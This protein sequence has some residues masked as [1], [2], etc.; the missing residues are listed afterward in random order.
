MRESPSLLAVKAL[1]SLYR[2]IKYAGRIAPTMNTEHTNENAAPMGVRSLTI[3][4]N[5]SPAQASALAAFAGDRG[6]S[7]GDALLLLAAAKMNTEGSL[8]DE[9]EWID[10]LAGAVLDEGRAGLVAEG[11]PL[12]Y[13]A[14]DAAGYEPADESQP[15]PVPMIGGKPFRGVA[16]DDGEDWKGE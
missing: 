2:R 5:V 4:V 14:A 16:G 3:S 13:E 1:A 7:A 9:A 8:A 6:I 11:E 15:R 12:P 10:E